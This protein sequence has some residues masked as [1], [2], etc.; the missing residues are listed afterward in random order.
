MLIRQAHLHTSSVRVSPLSATGAQR[1]AAGTIV[2]CELRNLVND[3]D[4]KK[5]QPRRAAFLL[6]RWRVSTGYEGF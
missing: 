2:N 1:R 4:Y 6:A 3:H 5:G